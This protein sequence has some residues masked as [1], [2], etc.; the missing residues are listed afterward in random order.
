M[1]AVTALYDNGV[2]YYSSN[3]SKVILCS[4]EP[5][6]DGEAAAMKLA[7]K[8][9]LTAGSPEDNPSGGRRVLLSGITNGTVGVGGTATHYAVLTAGNNLLYAQALVAAVDV[10]PGNTWSMANVYYVH[11]SS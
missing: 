2:S 10:A 11:P 4:D 9:G 8:T 6:T 7:E 5:T 1:F 3:A